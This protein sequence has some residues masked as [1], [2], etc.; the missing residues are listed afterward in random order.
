M[1]N[2]TS[3]LPAGQAT[4][5]LSRIRNCA[6]SLLRHG[7]IT[8]GFCTLIAVVLWLSKPGQRFDTQLAYSMATGLSS[9]L[10]IDLS[11][12]FV[13]VQSPLGYPRR[14]RGVLL[15][16]IGV[17]VGFLVGTFVG[18][19]YSGR[20]TFALLANQPLF[21]LYLFLF[22]ASVGIA[23]SFFFLAS[24]KSTYL[25]QELETT[26]RQALEARLKLLETQLEP[27]MLFNTLAN[28]RA[29]I[30][31]DA[32]RAQH[33]LD[34]LIAYLR[35]T[36]DASRATSHP[37]AIEFDR[38]RDYLDIM[39]VRMGS[40]L[41]Y[42][43]DLP[44]AL[45]QL[46]LPP[47]LLQPLVENSIKHGLEP[48]IEG[49]AIHISARMLAGALTIEVS[50]TGLGIGIGIGIGKASQAVQSSGR[51]QPGQTPGGFGLS[52]VKERLLTTYGNAAGFAVSQRPDGGT[53][54]T[55]TLPA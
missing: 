4:G 48:K 36:L 25:T 52:Q 2:L 18:D 23:I 31:T 32:P 21:F 43:L 26:K 3:S 40:R 24:G 51:T 55:I 7:L 1:H 33:M 41:H 16:F 47:L 19:A 11:R 8:V 29:L 27:H 42:T 15:I 20:S 14:W 30:A 53:T 35:A 17:S 6:P 22:T 54:V 28:L 13:D 12:F 49:G 44:P 45:A 39:S 9:W 50:D 38:L 5:P 10:V 46:T 37:L 34:N